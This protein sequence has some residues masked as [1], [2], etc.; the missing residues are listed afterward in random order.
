MV[1]LERGS[2]MFDPGETVF[3]TENIGKMI[4]KFDT[5]IALQEGTIKQLG[6]KDRMESIAFA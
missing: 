4:D 2:A 3:R 5:L 6:N 1:T